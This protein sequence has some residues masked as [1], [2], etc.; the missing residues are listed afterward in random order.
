MIA[1]LKM[2]CL[3]RYVSL[4]SVQTSIGIR[5]AKSKPSQAIEFFARLACD[6]LPGLAKI[7]QTIPIEMSM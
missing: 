5:N 1:T 4:R 2:C 7:E 3:G 6:F